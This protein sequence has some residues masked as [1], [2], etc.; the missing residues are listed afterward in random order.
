VPNWAHKKST[1]MT[2]QLILASSSKPRQLLLQRLRIPFVIAPSHVDETPLLN[3]NPTDMVLRLA[4]E[5][6]YAVTNQFPNAVFIGADQVGLLENTI[7]GK[8]LNHDNAIKQLT[9]LSGKLVRFLI[10]LCVLDTKN[11]TEQV[12]LETYD[13]YFRELTLTMIENY[14]KKE[15]ALE[16][17]GSF[18]AEGLG[19]TLVERFSGNDF[20]ALIGLPLIKLTQMLEHAKM[21][22]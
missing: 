13:V 6:A 20:T 5:K 2:Q 9:F 4:K 3:E 19:I 14:L 22:F 8:P 15:S 16:C 7:L 11:N 1:C 21:V 17:A 12:S 18:K 10:G